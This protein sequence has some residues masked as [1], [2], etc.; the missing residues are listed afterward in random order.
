MAI[1][2]N[3]TIHKAQSLPRTFRGQ[4][5]Y[6]RKCGPRKVRGFNHLK[7]FELAHEAIQTLKI[8][9]KLLTPGERETLELVSDLETLSDLQVSLDEAAQKKLVPLKTILKE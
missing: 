8:T 5:F 9:S 6:A 3:M 4:N 7:A 1:L 2:K